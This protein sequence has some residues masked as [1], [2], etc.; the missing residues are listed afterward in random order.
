MARATIKARRVHCV[1]CKRLTASARY[2][3]R[4]HGSNVYDW[5]LGG[6]WHGKCADEAIRQALKDTVRRRSEVANG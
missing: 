1:G 2:S 3:N 5:A 6:T 4:P